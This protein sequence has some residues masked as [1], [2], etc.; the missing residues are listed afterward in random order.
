[1]AQVLPFPRKEA[2]AGRRSLWQI[3]EPVERHRSP[4]QPLIPRSKAGTCNHSALLHLNKLYYWELDV[5][6]PE[7]PCHAH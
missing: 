6:L 1:M 7:D 2:P 3:V 5:L 4:L